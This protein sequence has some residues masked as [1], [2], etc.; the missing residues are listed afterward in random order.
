MI[1]R[2]R[3]ELL[4]SMIPN[5]APPESEGYTEDGYIRDQDCF[6]R[7]TYRTIPACVNCCG[8][9][10]VFNLRRFR[11][12]SVVFSEVLRE[13]DRLHLLRAPGP[14]RMYVMRLCLLRWLPGWREAKGRDRCLSAARR[15]VMGIFRYRE[16]NVPHF[17]A[18]F[19]V[20]E[21]LF[22]FFNIGAGTED[23]VF[24]I[25]RFG[26]EHCVAEPVRLIYWLA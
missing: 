18:Y 19:R 25:E 26:A 3:A 20:G 15:S 22:R 6:S 11:G 21:G 24:S 14:T 9:V 16:E 1:R 2:K 23:V 4:K 17:V 10:A 13:M 8:C 12:Q 7:E 5:P